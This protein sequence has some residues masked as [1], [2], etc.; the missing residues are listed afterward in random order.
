MAAP[1]LTSVTIGLPVAS[2]PD[3]SAWY[4]RLLGR[5]ADLEPV[6]GIEEFEPVPGCWLQLFEGAS[7]SGYECVV[8][9]GVSDIE[10]ARARLVGFGIPVGP[11]ERVEGVIAFCDFTDPWGNQLSLYQVLIS[12]AGSRTGCCRRGP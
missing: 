11:I 4:G 1:T 2:L 12:P 8:R 3:A 7:G 9:F 6:P 5:S 10:A